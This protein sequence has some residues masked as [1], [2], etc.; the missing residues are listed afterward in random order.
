VAW[1]GDAV[2]RGEVEKGEGSGDKNIGGGD[3]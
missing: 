1:E 2:K 3:M